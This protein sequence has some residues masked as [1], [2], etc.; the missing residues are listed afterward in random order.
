[1]SFS[2]DVLK[3]IMGFLP[4]PELI[5]LSGV[6]KQ[7]NKCAAEMPYRL[8]ELFSKY[9][10]IERAF[11]KN[12]EVNSIVDKKTY[13]SLRKALNGETPYKVISAAKV[14]SVP[15]G[16][17]MV[18]NSVWFSYSGPPRF[19]ELAQIGG[20]P[21]KLVSETLDTYK[22]TFLITALVPPGE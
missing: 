10:F 4:S 21:V 9:A 19:R 18:P 13:L 3:V 5:R 15:Y 1:M 7:W 12:I 16:S 14:L 17:R 11:F 8:T 2:N 20:K 22:N 6:S